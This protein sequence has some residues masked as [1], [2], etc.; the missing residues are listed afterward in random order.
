MTS[1][2]TLGT[3]L[4]LTI[5]LL[6]SSM[7]AGGQG[8]GSTK[9]RTLLD[10]ELVSVAI[11]LYKLNLQ[12]PTL[13]AKAFRK[14]SAEAGEGLFSQLFSDPIIVL[15]LAI[16]HNEGNVLAHFYLGESYYSKSY[17]GEGNWT[18]L[19]LMKAEEQY[20]FVVSKASKQPVPRELLIRSQKALGDIRQTLQEMGP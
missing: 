8:S 17:E 19:L 18:R 4:G 2:G 6:T 13:F 7:A 5:I 9:R 11:Q 12:I 10:Q 1:T 15:Q 20:S 3:I 14:Q 16:R